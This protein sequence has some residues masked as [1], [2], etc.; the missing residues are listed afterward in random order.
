[1][2]ASSAYFG[3]LVWML[4][5]RTFPAVSR[6]LASQTP[7]VMPRHTVLEEAAESRSESVPSHLFSIL[8]AYI[9]VQV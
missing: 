2:F 5:V 4:D 9:K 1:M 8:R 3:T 7:H 6:S